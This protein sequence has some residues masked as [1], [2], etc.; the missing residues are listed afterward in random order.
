[1]NARTGPSREAASELRKLPRTGD[2][3][4]VACRAGL[5]ERLGHG[6]VVECI[7]EAL[8][9]L[10][11][12]VMPGAACPGP[13]EIERSML[14]RLA[15][16]ERHRG[17]HPHQS[18]A[19]ARRHPLLRALRVD[20]VTLASLSAT[21]AHYE[22]GEAVE[23]AA[24]IAAVRAAL[25]REPMRRGRSHAFPITAPAC[26]IET[27]ISASAQSFSPANVRALNA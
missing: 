7:R 22:R 3:L 21:L 19:R 5:V 26:G 27:R 15:D 23:D 1:M 9:A 18:R 20:E 12:D 4:E 16:G 6:W 10:R 13:G 2:L 8:E 24:V 11:R 17:G 14:E 25:G